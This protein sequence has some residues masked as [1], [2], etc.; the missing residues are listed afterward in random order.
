MGK[1]SESDIVYGKKIL[2]NNMLAGFVQVKTPTN[3][4]N[5]LRFRIIGLNGGAKKHKIKKK[6]NKKIKTHYL[7]LQKN[8]GAGVKNNTTKKPVSLETAVKLLKRYYEEKYS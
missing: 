2:D 4:D 8:K 5:G 1:Y 6:N 7:N 3:T